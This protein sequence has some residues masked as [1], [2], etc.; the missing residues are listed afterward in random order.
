MATQKLADLTFAMVVC[1]CAVSPVLLSAV[2]SLAV[3]FLVDT[4]IFSVP[5]LLTGVFS[6]PQP[7][8]CLLC[9]ML[10]PHL[11]FFLRN[12]SVLHVTY[13]CLRTYL[14]CASCFASIFIFHWFWL[15]IETFKRLLK[16][17]VYLPGF[18]THTLTQKWCCSVL[19]ECSTAIA[20]GYF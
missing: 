6:R 10:L 11:C 7:S 13:F 14:V 9:C 8:C 18:L 5:H 16:P 4:S 3:C 1:F 2:A 12:T 20:S 19:I 17:A 15:T